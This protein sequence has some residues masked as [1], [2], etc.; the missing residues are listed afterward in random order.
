MIIE[1]S[2]VQTNSSVTSEIDIKIQSSFEF[3]RTVLQSSQNRQNNDVSLIEKTSSDNLKAKRASIYNEIAA[4]NLEFILIN[5]LN[6]SPEEAKNRTSRMCE[7]NDPTKANLSTSQEI[8]Y[9]K[10]EVKIQRSMEYFKKDSIDFST[11]AI[12]K[13]NTQDINLDINISYS[14]ELYEKYE[15]RLEYSQ[16]NVIDPLI[17]QYGADA[18]AFDFLDK[19]MSFSFDLD[20]NG[21]ENELASLKQGN[22]F[23]ALDKNSNGKIDDGLELFGPSTNN[24]FEELRSYDSDGNSW[25][26]ENDSIFNDL[27][28]WSKNEEGEDQMLSLKDAN[29]GAIYLK[30]EETKISIDKSINDPLAHL[31]STSFFLKDDGSAGL[32]SSLDF[33]S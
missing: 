8:R 19:D 26:D 32:L 9:V 12:I 25:L 16:V 3:K 27:I 4:L 11:K 10:T 17:I 24:A 29:V 2:Q 15:K 28:I 33:I 1:S 13:T 23:L 7:C 20:A 31:K 6:V 14:Q 21:S 22:G 5:F 30:D 18:S